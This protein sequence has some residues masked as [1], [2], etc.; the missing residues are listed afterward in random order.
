MSIVATILAALKIALLFFQTK[1]ER[2]KE[3]KAKLSK[4]Y[5]EALNGIEESDPARITAAFDSIKRVR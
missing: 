5:K 1:I 2:D 3:R 4:A